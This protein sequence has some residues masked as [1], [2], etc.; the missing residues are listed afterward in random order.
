M[1]VSESDQDDAIVEALA[2]L[3]VA[4]F[5]REQADLNGD[6]GPASS[7]SSILSTSHSVAPITAPESERVRV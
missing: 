6:R 1:R 2:R 4:E 5:R 3:L 7:D